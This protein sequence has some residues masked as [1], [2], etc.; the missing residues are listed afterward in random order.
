MEGFIARWRARWRRNNELGGLGRAEL[1]RVAGELGL[2]A[3]AL[4]D[5]AARGPHAADLLYER[6][7]ALG[8]TKPDVEHMAPGL[9]RD[10]QKSC[11]GCNDKAACRKGL[12]SRPED[13]VWKG[14]CP[15]RVTLVSIS[16]M[17]GR[18]SL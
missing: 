17:K 15:N 11:S 3:H 2:S 8:L 9:M 18:S 5:L 4:E 13:P 12:A 7:A 1:E 6:M 10:L 16:K 14:Y